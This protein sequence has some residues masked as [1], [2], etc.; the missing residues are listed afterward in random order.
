MKYLYYK[1]NNANL[2]LLLW[3]GILFSINSLDL[4]LIK[5]YKL[6]FNLSL[7]YIYQLINFIRFILP[8]VIFTILIFFLFALKKKK[9]NNLLTIFF[10]YIIWQI[11]IFFFLGIKDNLLNNL[12]L[13]INS[14]SVLLILDNI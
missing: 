8:F 7:N 1:L 13:T 14:I 10:I 2:L 12:Q 5:F 9:L 11:L 6:E 3:V 4:D